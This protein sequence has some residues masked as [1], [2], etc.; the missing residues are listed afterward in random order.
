MTHV[1]S[2]LHLNSLEST[3]STTAEERLALVERICRSEVFHRSPRLRELLTYIGARAAAGRTG[4]LTE[5]KIAQEVFGRQDYSPAEDNVVRAA[6]RQLRLKVTHYFETEGHRESLILEIPKGGYNPVFRRV[7]VE[8]QPETPRILPPIAP[9][10]KPNRLPWLMAL[11]TAASLAFGIFEWSA[12][13][14]TADLKTPPTSLMSLLFTGPF[15]RTTI[16]VA[17][18]AFVVVQSLNKDL[19]RLEDYTDGQYIADTADRFGSPDLK[20]MF[21]VLRTRQT[22]SIADLRITS[23][24]LERYAARGGDIVISHARNVRV[25]DFSTNDNFLLFGSKLSNPWTTLFEAPLNF[26]F[27]KAPVRGVRIQNLHP[28]PG[29]EEWYMPKDPVREVG[30]DYAL[31]TLQ[32]NHSGTGRVMTIAGTMMEG[33]EAAGDF[34]LNPKNLAPILKRLGAQSVQT[35]PD[36]QLLLQTRAIGGAGREAVIVADR[37]V[38]PR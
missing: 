23:S 27:E 30:T 24:I 18:S 22:T 28:R 1:G 32:H 33:T 36:F 13:H 29:E 15:P 14:R 10:V 2:G 20:R 26:R 5:T 19:L 12:N 7:P 37:L 25:R 8:P 34:A 16:V 6:A 35:L 17:D 21:E 3:T 4:D 9:P 31:I 38:L 11:V